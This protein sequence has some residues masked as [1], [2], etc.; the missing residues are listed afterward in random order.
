MPT[1]WLG[2]ATDVF[3]TLQKATILSQNCHTHQNLILLWNNKMVK[4]FNT[5][6]LCML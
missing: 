2:V 4:I 1:T 5:Y 3:L 6:Q